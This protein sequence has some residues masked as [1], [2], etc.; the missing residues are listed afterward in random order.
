MHWKPE[1]LRVLVADGSD[2]DGRA[3]CRVLRAL[4]H[5]VAAMVHDEDQAMERAAAGRP[6]LALVDVALTEAD[7]GVRTA[8]RLWEELGVPVVFATRCTDVPTVRR[9]LAAAPLGYLIKPVV[10]HVLDRCLRQAMALTVGSPEYGERITDR[11]IM[12]TTSIGR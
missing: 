2:E 1:E 11:E 3:L 4:G 5:E 8:H 9:A 12:S 10:P 6:D 7:A